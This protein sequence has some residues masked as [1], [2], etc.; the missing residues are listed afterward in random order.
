[1]TVHTNA[2]KWEMTINGEIPDEAK[3]KSPYIHF[4]SDWDELVIEE[5]DPEFESCN[6][7]CMVQE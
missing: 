6:C 5:G 3:E 7:F 4:C 2:E 1:M